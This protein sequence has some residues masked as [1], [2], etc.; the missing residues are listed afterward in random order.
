[1][2]EPRFALVRALWTL[3]TL[4]GTLVLP[5]LVSALLALLGALWIPLLPLATGILYDLLYAAPHAHGFFSGTLLGAL[6]TGLAYL[7]RT[8]VA[9]GIITG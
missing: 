5:W 7:V 6:L 1:M 8:R 3:G 4:L 2:R 9:P